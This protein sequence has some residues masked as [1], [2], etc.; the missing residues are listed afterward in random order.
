M[1]YII[2]SKLKMRKLRHLGNKAISF[3]AQGVYDS[4]FKIFEF[5]FI[6]FFIQQVLI[7]L[8]LISKK[9]RRIVKYRFS[10]FCGK[11]KITPKCLTVI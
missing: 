10:K 9:K 3:L 4:F 7:S 8:I 5:Y 6:Y 11:Y 1:L 2:G